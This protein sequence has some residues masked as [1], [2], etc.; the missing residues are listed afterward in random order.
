MKP[1]SIGIV[2]QEYN[3][4]PYTNLPWSV[5]HMSQFAIRAS[6][7]YEPVCGGGLVGSGQV[8]L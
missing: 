1:I 2:P 5:C 7:P 4:S 6:S 8:R 3:L